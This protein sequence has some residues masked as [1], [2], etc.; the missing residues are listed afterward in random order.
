[1]RAIKADFPLEMNGASGSG[2][3]LGKPGTQDTKFKEALVLG[4]GLEAS[5]AICPPHNPVNLHY[6][7]FRGT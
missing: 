6:G 2:P 3:G 4:M 7:S 5:L 1:M